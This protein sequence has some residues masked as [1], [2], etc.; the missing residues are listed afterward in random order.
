MGMLDAI[1]TFFIGGGLVA[2]FNFILNLRKQRQNETADERTYI[3]DLQ[4]RVLE[5]NNNMLKNNSELQTAVL[6]LTN[7]L[8]LTNSKLVQLQCKYDTAQLRITEL[9]TAQERTR[10]LL[11][12]CPTSCKVKVALV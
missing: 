11:I 12:N 5:F 4:N 1:I 7:E 2:I 3:Q 8:A 10:G 6:A 9:E